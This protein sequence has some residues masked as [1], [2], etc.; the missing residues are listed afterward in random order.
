[1]TGL[2]SH[3]TRPSEMEVSPRLLNYQ[4]PLIFFRSLNTSSNSFESLKS[5]RSWKT[6]KD[7]FN[8]KILLDHKSSDLNRINLLLNCTTA[9]RKKMDA[10]WLWASNSLPNGPQYSIMVEFGHEHT[11]SFFDFNSYEYLPV[12]RTTYWA[13]TGRQKGGKEKEVGEK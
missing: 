2:G 10:Y 1:M 4:S 7:N 6:N 8:L 3:K 12:E 13:V 5:I 11:N 9:R